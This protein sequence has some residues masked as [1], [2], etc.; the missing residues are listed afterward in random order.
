[1]QT[2]VNN[3]KLVSREYTDG[4][5]DF[6]SGM[7]YEIN[8]ARIE[9][10]TRIPRAINDDHFLS[11]ATNGNAYNVN[12]KDASAVAVILHPKSLWAGETIP[13]TSDVFFSREEKQWFIDSFLAFGVTINRP[14]CCG[15]VFKFQG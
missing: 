15:A 5:G 1:M 9:K 11:N 10:N 3:D 14:D 2:L 13:L 4:G 6:G 12:A 7:V 8:G